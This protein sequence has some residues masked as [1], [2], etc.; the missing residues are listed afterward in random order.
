MQGLSQ[1]GEIVSDL[2][3]IMVHDPRETE[4]SNRTGVHFIKVK[5]HNLAFKRQMPAFSI[6][7]FITQ[8][9]VFKTPKTGV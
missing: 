9:L 7:Y 8:L 6:S 4:G 5:R 2:K 1:W 3:G